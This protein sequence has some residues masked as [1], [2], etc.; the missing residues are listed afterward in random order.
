MIYSRTIFSPTNSLR[1]ALHGLSTETAVLHGLSDILQ[2]VNEDHVAVLP[3]LDPSAAFDTVDCCI[4]LYG[5]YSHLWFRSYL[6][7]QRRW[8]PRQST[9]TAASC[10][11]PQES[12]PGPIL[13]IIYTTDFSHSLC[14]HLFA[15]DTQ[16]NGCYSSSLSCSSSYRW[17]LPLD[18]PW[19]GIDHLLLSTI[20]AST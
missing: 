7:S 17:H 12:V 19:I 13:L 1:T 2:A 4:L 5:V 20:W 18:A 10:G 16:V 14:Q 3:L 11:V 6:S 15:D 8:G 9:T